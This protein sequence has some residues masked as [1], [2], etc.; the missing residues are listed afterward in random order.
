MTVDFL[1]SYEHKAREIEAVTLI[2]AE[3]ERRGY[4]VALTCT[5]DPERIAFTRS[6]SAK[7][8]VTSAL[9]NDGGLYGFVYSVAGFCKKVVNLQWEQALTNQDESDPAFYQN[10]KGRARTAVHVCWG[11]AAQRRLL[12]AGVPSNRAPVLG[13]IQMDFASP[14][15]HEFYL[16][17]RAIAASFNLDAS[18]DWVLFISSFTFV[19]MS[20][21]EYA[22]EV[23]SMGPSLDE[24]RT[25]SIQSKAAIV[26]WL[27][28]AATEYADK[29]FIYRPH[30]SENRDLDLAD[31]ERRCPNFRVI[32]EL[33][34]K[35]WIR[36]CDTLL[37]WYS[38]SAAE[39]FFLDK[40]CTILRPVPIPFSWD[41]SI[42]RGANAV[43]DLDSFLACLK[44]TGERFPLD[45]ALLREY[46]DVDPRTPSYM[47]VC[48]LL[49]RVFQSE[50]Y[51]MPPSSLWFRAW[52]PLERLRHR[53][54]F[55]LKELIVKTNYRA[56]LL[57]HRHLIARI[58]NHRA[59]MDRLRRDRWKNQATVDELTE[60]LSKQRRVVNGR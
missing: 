45:E 48:D 10:P 58:E 38:T 22:T 13:P 31:L 47:R 26:E 5:Y 7:V 14:A 57:H 60:L 2:Q 3:L 37:T 42:Y 29:V 16:T 55:V 25:L 40:H 52:L 21:E 12:T 56:L 51:D 17:K 23:R 20:A 36:C 33:P 59:V 43:S 49:E 32:G 19:N 34:V 4:S 50:D 41:V 39:A 35:Q 24:F 11:P 46:F 54:F 28:R 9:Y 44:T 30:P 6:Y 53:V 8:V 27:Q 15:F 1:I 18:K